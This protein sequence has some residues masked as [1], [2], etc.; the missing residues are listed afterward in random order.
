MSFDSIE[1]H[2]HKIRGMPI[3]L[4]FHLAILYG[5]ETKRLNEQVR[6]NIK[7]ES[8]S[9]NSSWGPK[10]Q[11]KRAFPE[12]GIMDLYGERRKCSLREILQ[13]FWAG[14]EFLMQDLVQRYLKWNDSRHA[15]SHFRFLWIMPKKGQKNLKAD[16]KAELRQKFTLWLHLILVCQN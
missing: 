13:G 11:R 10:A 12:R 5:V 1:N 7:P 4:D 15:E 2:I 9:R 14:I 16:T 3:M 6:R 8:Y